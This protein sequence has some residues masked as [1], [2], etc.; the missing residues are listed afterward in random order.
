MKME[1]ASMTRGDRAFRLVIA[2]DFGT[3]RSGYAYAYTDDKRIIGRAEWPGQP[4]PYPKT[5]TH[6]LYAADGKPV[7]WGYDARAKLAQLRQNQQAKEFTFL[8]NFKMQLHEGKVQN[9][10]GPVLTNANGRNFLVVDVISDY[11]SYLKEFAL[12]EIKDSV[13]GQ[14]R[15]DEVLW[16]L[17]VPAIWT[18]REKQLMRLAAQRA[19][20]IGSHALESDRLLLV[21]EPEAAA[22]H[23]QEKAKIQLGPGTRFMVVD[24][25]GGTVDLTAHEVVTGK[26]LKE[27]AAGTGGAHG[28]TYID[29]GFLEYLNTTLTNR[30]LECFHNEEP[31]DY[32]EMMADWERTKCNFD[33]KSSGEVI[34]FPIRAR[35]YKLLTTKYPD[36]LK[37]LAEEQGGADDSIHLSQA[38]MESIFRPV[39]DGVL[40]TVR[41]QL[42]RL[43]SQTCDYIFLV[44]GFST[45][46]LLRQ[47]INS[48]F[49]GVVKEIVVPTVPGGAVVEGAVSFGLDPTKIRARHSRLTYGC[50]VSERFRPGIDPENKKFWAKDKA[51]WY[52]TDRFSMFVRAG[53]PVGVNEKVPHIYLPIEREQTKMSLRFYAAS[54]ARVNYVDEEGVEPIGEMTADMPNTTGGVDR[55]LEVSMFFGKTEIQVE[56]RDKTSGKQ[57]KT[58][59]RFSSTFSPELIGG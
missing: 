1:T 34:Y 39:L 8:Q 42:R 6:L 4:V 46:P 27:I 18:N 41:E 11:L 29:R 54:K 33:P 58:V 56:A 7:A 47:S 17:T 44:G 30:V 49:R 12:Q 52:C 13:A 5:L 51:D 16:C 9:E 43:G 23:C 20:L 48:E 40:S 35:L 2:I 25:G 28:S 31:I 36:V 26:G 14:L 37:K 32:L 15:E 21:L 45:C 19:G 22:I 53:Q 3:S 59:L 38:T 24:C 57:C 10:N 55:K 50:R